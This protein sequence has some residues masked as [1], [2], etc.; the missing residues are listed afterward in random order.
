MKMEP[1]SDRWIHTGPTQ[2]L[3]V[4]RAA[5]IRH[6]CI[7]LVHQLNF[8]HP[9]HL[10]RR[11][12]VGKYSLIQRRQKWSAS[13]CTMRHCRRRCRS[14]PLK[15]P[16]TGAADGV[17]GRKWFGVRL[18]SSVGSED[19]CVSGRLLSIV[20]TSVSSVM[21]VSSR[22]ARSLSTALR[23]VFTDLTSRSHAPPMCGVAG[24]LNSHLI[25]LGVSSA[26]RRVWSSWPND[27]SSSLSAP[28]RC[29][30]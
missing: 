19:T 9:C 26:V 29:T 15:T 11:A 30:S 14:S 3:R 6:V 7:T 22:G 23:A 25:P 21:S 4:Q 24:G 17:P 12:S 27:S 20:S 10:V 13:T 2:S 1:H 28:R 8:G 16:G 5:R 18:L